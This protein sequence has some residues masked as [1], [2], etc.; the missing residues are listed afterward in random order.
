MPLRL[1]DSLAGANVVRRF[2]RPASRLWHFLFF[3]VPGKQ[4]AAT[5][6]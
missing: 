6:M 4:V 2:S 1:R 3:D 5:Y